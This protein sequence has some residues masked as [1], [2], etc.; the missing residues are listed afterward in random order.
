M[1]DYPRTKPRILHIIHGLTTGGA[2]IDLLRKLR[3]FSP[4][5]RA[6]MSICCLM[7]RGELADEAARL[8]VHV[9][10]PLMR[11]RT[12][13][14]V[15]YRLRRLITAGD[16]DIVHSHLFAAN[17]VTW[18]AINTVPASR[19]PAWIASEHAMAQRWNRRVLWTDRQMAQQACIFTVPTESAAQSYIARGLLPAKIRVAANAV[20]TAHFA[21]DDEERVARRRT[22]RA[23][24]GIDDGTF[25]I[26]TVCRLEPVKNLTMLIDAVTPLNVVLIIVGDGS[27]RG[28]LEQRIESQGLGHKVRF[29]GRRRDI[30]D[31]LSAFD[32]FAQTSLSE[33]FGLAVIEALLTGTPVVATAV[34]A[35][36]EVTDGGRYATLTPP[37]DVHAFRQALLH[38]QAYPTAAHAQAR[39]AGSFIA[40]NY[41]VDAVA[42]ALRQL[43]SD[44]LT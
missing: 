15:V 32:V 12:D 28:E 23:S 11:T 7:R 26:G 40:A 27:L 22:A 6:A 42:A 2:E 13:A 29:L 10:G 44:V 21:C 17:A 35:I 33:S 30:P 25:V 41:G 31:L 9:T 39:A 14:L 5:A 1:T 43:Y 18:V 8:G 36:P 20:D 24:L 4:E 19:R 38:S 34:G 37:D 16:I 3:V